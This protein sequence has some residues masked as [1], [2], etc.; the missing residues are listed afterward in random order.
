MKI[1]D[2]YIRVSTDEQAEKGYS[3]RDQEERLRAYCGKFGYVVGRVM[4]EDHSAKSFIRPEWKKYMQFLKTKKNRPSLLL[5][6]KWDRFSRN[7]GD[8]YQMIRILGE[9]GIDPQAVEQ[10]ID[11]SIPENK[12]MLAFFLSAP[13]VE[14]D[15]RALNVIHG[16]RRA[17]KEGRLMGNAPFGYENKMTEKGRKYIDRKEPEASIMIQIFKEIERGIFSPEQIRANLKRAG[18]R[19]LSRNAFHNAIR[20]VAYCGLVYVARYKDEE[21]Q[22]VK[23]QHEALISE[24]LFNQVQRI[25][26]GRSRKPVSQAKILSDIN[27]PLRGF[28]VC[29]KCGG[30]ITGSAS[31]GRTIRYYYYHCQPGC[32]YRVPAPLAND[33]FENEILKKMELK[34]IYVSILKKLLDENYK[35][36]IDFPVFDRDEVMKELAAYRLKMSS[37]RDKLLRDIIDDDDYLIVKKECK[38]R[39][40]ELESTLQ[41][42]DP[43]MIKFEIEKKLSKAVDL[44]GNVWKLYE[45]GGIEIKRQI[46]GSIF[47]NKLE[48]DGKIYR[49]ASMNVVANRIFQITNGLSVNKKRLNE[50]I[51]HLACLVPRVGIEPTHRSTR[52]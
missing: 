1:A 42:C 9:Y 25:L 46:I 5:F 7:A 23:G 41:N 45:C 47:P 28:L 26:E 37:A 19:M 16:L 22:Y 8:A 35:Q 29:P 27:F 51:S 40:E 21:E 15:R 13:E 17:K 49:T 12:L 10:P 11:L 32:N 30:K 20:N 34:P 24:E 14:N 6:T 44:I 2:L 36:F 4:F 43:S 39:I 52:V 33:I 48:F 38:E 31:K 3:Q 18:N 50:D